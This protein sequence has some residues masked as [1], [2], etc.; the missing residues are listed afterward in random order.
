MLDKD[1][2]TVQHVAVDGLCG[3][4]L[5][6]GQRVVDDAHVAGCLPDSDSK[7]GEGPDK[8]RQEGTGTDSIAS[9]LGSLNLMGGD[10]VKV[11]A[12]HDKED[13]KA[14]GADE[15]SESSVMVPEEEHCAGGV[16]RGDGDS[17]GSQ[18]SLIPPRS[19]VLLLVDKCQS[20]L[21][22]VMDQSSRWGLHEWSEN[23]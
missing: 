6:Y 18:S 2:L 7:Q 17:G 16:G 21:K 8:Q 20:I 4:I 15:E 12:G 10:E 11:E 13:S 3:M 23:V 1:T 22:Q 19:V 14:A 5:V 9:A